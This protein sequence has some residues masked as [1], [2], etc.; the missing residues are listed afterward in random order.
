MSHFEEQRKKQQIKGANAAV[1]IV[2]RYQDGLPPTNDQIIK[3][4]DSTEA[5]LD[6]SKKNPSANE[7]GRNIIRDSESLLDAARSLLEKRNKDETLQRFI[8]DAKQATSNSELSLDTLGPIGEREKEKLEMLRKQMNDVAHY[9]RIGLEH[10]LRSSEFRSIITDIID[11][12]NAVY[13]KIVEKDIS[14]IDDAIDAVKESAQEVLEEEDAVRMQRKMYR[15]FK[16]LLGRISASPEH[17]KAVDAFFGLI[18]KFEIEVE[19]EAE[20][21]KQS[22]RLSLDEHALRATQDAKY[23]IE[24][25]SGHKT[26]DSLVEELKTMI[27]TMKNDKELVDYFTEVKEVIYKAFTDP[28]LLDDEDFIDE[29]LDLMKKGK[30]IFENNDY[31]DSAKKL[32]KKWN[33]VV[34]NLREND[35][36]NAFQFAFKKLISDISTVDKE[37]NYK[38]DYEALEQIR[39]LVIPIMIEQL[40]YIPVEN[41]DGSNEYYDFNIRNIVLSGYEIFPRNIKVQSKMDMNIVLRGNQPTTANGV[42][43]MSS[44]NITTSLKDLKFYYRRK[45]FPYLEDE[46]NADLEIGGRGLKVKVKFNVV[47]VG[48]T[49][50]IDECF[51]WTHIDKLDLKIHNSNHDFLYKILRGA[52]SQNVKTE[53]EKQIGDSLAHSVGL[54]KEK[55][56]TLLHKAT[57]E[58]WGENLSEKF[59]AL[60]R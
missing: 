55:I 46:G 18:E 48:S 39:I 11:F 27:L 24:Q 6:E 58:A 31:Q 17:R 42:I 12:F 32:S 57:Q 50:R 28:E 21:I 13:F 51:V 8:L 19:N 22:L 43:V 3:V 45:S 60:M 15:R 49:L 29:T 30:D 52:I 56:N 5:A 10:V 37:G 34:R 20:N 54:A 9:G 4:I 26:I 44:E 23:I 47:G 33:T 1:E 40:K 16:A 7:K 36:L 41:I 38:L 2:R 59:S 53:L 35:E 14:A 25:F